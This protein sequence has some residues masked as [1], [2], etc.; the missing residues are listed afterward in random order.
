MKKQ[1]YDVVFNDDTSSNSVGGDRTLKEAYDYI[2][3]NNGSDYGYFKDYQNGF[4]S[5][6]CNET[7]ETVHTEKVKP[8]DLKEEVGE[9]LFQSSSNAEPERTVY[10]DA[11]EFID[12]LKEQLNMNFSGTK[13]NVLNGDPELEREVSDIYRDFFGEMGQLKMYS[14]VAYLQ[15]DTDTNDFA[16]MEQEKNYKGMLQLAREHDSGNAID[17]ENTYYDACHNPMDHLVCEDKDYAVVV[18]NSVGGTYEIFRK[19]SITE[20]L[21]NVLIFGLDKI[22]SDVKKCCLQCCDRKIQMMM[23]NRDPHLIMQ[24]TDPQFEAEHFAFRKLAT[25]ENAADRRF[26]AAHGDESILD[27]LVNDKE[28]AVRADVAKYGDVLHHDRLLNDSSP[29]V[30]EAIARYGDDAHRLSLVN[31]K[32]ADVRMTVASFG[33]ADVLAAMSGDKDERVLSHVRERAKTVGLDTVSRK[34]EN[35]SKNALSK[36]VEKFRKPKKQKSRGMKM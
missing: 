24:M 22:G 7:G 26:A 34:E 29:E 21:Q 4:V 1:T 17:L 12:E 33:N 36:F 9:I 20:V 31:D 35:G 18:N 13:A 23:L 2:E 25:S 16:G 15:F 30:R 32:D 28:P 3:I 19:C 27:M 5:I 11:E 10:T 8:Y 6:V 14:S